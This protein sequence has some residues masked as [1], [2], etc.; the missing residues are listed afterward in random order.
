MNNKGF[1]M[2]ELVATIALL[3]VIM[4]I[5]FVSINTAVDNSEI[6]ECKCRNNHNYKFGN[7]KPLTL[8]NN[9]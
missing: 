8:R 7:F 5:S 4:I 9:N 6:N 2:V 3:S 1:T